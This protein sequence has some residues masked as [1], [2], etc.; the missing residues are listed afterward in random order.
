MNKFGKELR[1]EIE[2]YVDDWQWDEESKKYA[3]DMGK[4]LYSFMDYLDDQNLSERTKR[5]HRDNIG[6]IGMFESGYGYNDEF[7][8]ENLEDGPSY[9][10]EFK[11]KVSDS[12]YAIQSYESTW[13]KLDKYIKSGKHEKYLEEVESKLKKIE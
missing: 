9:C 12:K 11:R 5:S 8:P 7:H 10:Y 1:I 3:F 13:R 6:L 2:D 4:F